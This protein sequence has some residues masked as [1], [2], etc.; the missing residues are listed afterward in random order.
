MNG[1][2]PYEGMAPAAFAGVV[3]LMAGMFFL[4]LVVMIIMRGMVQ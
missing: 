3:V 4:Y 2:D 1:V